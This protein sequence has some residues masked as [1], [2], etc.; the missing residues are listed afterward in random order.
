[1]SLLLAPINAAYAFYASESDDLSQQALGLFLTGVGSIDA[2][3]TN[4]LSTRL[5]Y[6]VDFNN[7]HLEYQQIW[8]QTHS[9][10]NNTDQTQ[11]DRLNISFNNEQ[12]YL[13]VGRQ[14][15]SLAT[16]FYFSPNDF[17]APFT[18]QSLNRDFKQGV[19]AVYSELQL[20]R[21]AGELSTL[22]LI[23]VNNQDENLNTSSILR[24]ESTLDNISWMMFMGELNQTA[25]SSQQVFGGSLQADL[26]DNLGIRAEGHR[27]KQAGQ[28]TSEWVFG[29]EQRLNA[30][31]TWSAE[32]FYHGAA[33]ITPHLP[34]AGKQYLA[35]GLNYQFTPLLLAN[36]S[37]VRN[38]DDQ[39]QLNTAYIN[40]SL[41]DE[42]TVNLS[43]LLPNGKNTAEF[44]LYPKVYALDFQIY[45]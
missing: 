34:Y 21:F 5:M 42:S 23:L 3:N 15:V 13:K 35:L 8:Q 30:D 12:F 44:G 33:A 43:V 41:S 4:F 32:W 17:F 14:A 45:F 22:S 37:I 6:D 7:W 25:F 1:M 40:Y 11:A 26:L 2:V 36:F 29:L 24:F 28:D 31:T 16:T 9:K 20:G 38:M 10:N 18:I 19:D 27:S 39:S